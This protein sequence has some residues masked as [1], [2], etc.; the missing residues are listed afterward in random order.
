MAYLVLGNGSVFEG[1]RIGY[2]TS[3]TIGELVF[4]TGMVGYL[5]TLTDPSY[6]G[7]IVVQTFP[8]IGNYG[9]IPDDF[10]GK[11]A[12]SGYVVRELCGTPSNFRSEGELDSWLNENKIPG[13]CGVDTR[14]ITRQIREQGVM[15]A[16]I[17][18]EIP[19]DLSQINSY[20][21]QNVLQQV[22]CAE[23][24]IYPAQGTKQY[25]ITLID[26][27]AK[28]NIIRS[29]QQRGCE[30]TVVPAF[31]SAETILAEDPDGVML[32]NGPGDPA[33]N[34]SCIAEIRKLIGQLPVFGICLGHQMAALA[35]G[36]KT[37]KLKYG[38][39]GGNQPATDLE[40]GRTYITSQNHGYAVDAGS[41]GETGIQTFVNANDGSC[42]GIRYPGK[43]C[44]TVQFHPEAHSGPQDTSFLF[45]RFIQMMGGK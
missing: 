23:P 34:V 14:E 24:Q 19:A 29:L 21:V 40:Y 7:Q 5:E 17:C 44:F 16:V 3:E 26:Y 35:M 38:H 2:K 36:G 11:P 22:T 39:R 20:L 41:L 42:E 18:D 15:N 30:V 45:D 12:V 32:S 33:E 8:L 4:T 1:Q 13:I 37:F 43:Q 28:R 27:G 31:T 9:V 10:E 25:A 6:A